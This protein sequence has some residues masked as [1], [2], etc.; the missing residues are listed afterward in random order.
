MLRALENP[1]RPKA[2]FIVLS[3]FLIIAIVGS[4]ETSMFFLLFI[5]GA[6]TA[7]NFWLKS[8]NRWIWLGL[9]SLTIL[10]SVIVIASPGN[11]IRSGMFQNRHRFF[12]SLGMALLQEVRFVA[13][14]VTNPAF[15][16]TTIL[17]LPVLDKIIEKNY[18]LKNHFF[19]HPIVTTILFF[20]L[21]LCGLFPPYWATGMLGQHRSV[22][23][24]C[25]FFLI[26]WFVLLAIWIAYLKSN[27]Q[28]IEVKLPKFVYVLGILMLIISLFATNNS[29]EVL[30][31]LV[32]GKATKYNQEMWQRSLQFEQCA[33]NNLTKCEV[34]PVQNLP[35]SI[36]N[37]N[38]F[39]PTSFAYEQN[40][41]KL[42]V[43]LTE[44]SEK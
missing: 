27:N 13:T 8:S 22:N 42:K 14:W 44:K 36:T 5:I 28:K 20:G 17:S 35:R 19:I 15:I 30:L 43:K 2:S 7:T 41:W 32:I 37:A 24:A 21:M 9:L 12:Y 25:F 33:K 16:L 11:E 29:R 3:Y 1:K 26:G 40:Y 34:N 38:Y 23:V 4:S 39:N 18:L 6:I 31:D 10:C